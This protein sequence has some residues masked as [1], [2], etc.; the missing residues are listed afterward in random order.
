[1]NIGEQLGDA[2]VAMAEAHDDMEA[3][4]TLMLKLH[5]LHDLTREWARLAKLRHDAAYERFIAAVREAC[6][7]SDDAADAL[8]AELAGWRAVT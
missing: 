7:A 8:R 2:H 4:I 6:A 5:E 1:M 3:A